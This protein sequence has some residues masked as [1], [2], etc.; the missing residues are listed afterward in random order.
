MIA[1]RRTRSRRWAMLLLTPAAAALFGV[2]AASQ[3]AEAAT[4]SKAAP[5]AI[6]PTGCSYGPS[7]L[8]H[9]EAHCTGGAGQY[10]V[11]AKCAGV[12]KYGPWKTVGTPG[13]STI[14]CSSSNPTNIG[15]GLLPD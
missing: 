13:S 3:P 5:L 1:T 9:A 12:Q 7:G 6:W 8:R 15:I 14:T 2:A 4:D 10:R 11:T